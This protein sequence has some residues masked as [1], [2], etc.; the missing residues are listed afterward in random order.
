MAGG[1]WKRDDVAAG[2]LSERSHFIPDRPRQ[3]EVLL[4]VVRS[5]EQATSMGLAYMFEPCL[6]C[7]AH[8]RRQVAIASTGDIKV[9]FDLVDFYH[10]EGRLFGVDT[11]KLGF[12]ECASVLRGLLKGI[13]SGEFKPPE[14]ETVTLDG[15]VSAYH[16]ID[17]GT[18]RTETPTT[19]PWCTI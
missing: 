13:E 18:A 19:G 15:A 7:L 10:R 8:R 4:R 9:S 3:L 6:K 11:L 17:S 5:A 2:Y 1:T 16:A 14:L 12:A